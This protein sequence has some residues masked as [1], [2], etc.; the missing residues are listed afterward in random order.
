MD[1]MNITTFAQSG[2]CDKMMDLLYIS[3]LSKLLNIPVYLKKDFFSYTDPKKFKICSWRQI[4]TQYNVL[5]NFINIPQIN[6]V[7]NY[8]S[9]LLNFNNYL[10][11]C[12]N[13]NDFNK[14]Y[15]TTLVNFGHQ[16]NISQELF[17]STFLE[18]CN[19]ITFKNLDINMFPENTI[20]I[21]LRRTD[22]ISNNPDEGMIHTSELDDLDNKTYK[23]IDRLS[24]KY[25][26]FFICSDDL[27]YLQKFKIYIEK[28][29][30]NCFYNK[31]DDFITYKDLYCLSKCTKILMS[32]KSSNFSLFA[33]LIGNKNII[34]IYD[35]DYL[36][37][38]K[39][40]IKFEKYTD[41]CT[42][43]GHQ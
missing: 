16:N 34:N 26:N 43:I 8:D 29:N 21:H 10:G 27:E 5:N 22:K 32:C 19:N 12:S 4:D 7:D 40:I 15:C 9:K 42:I 24:L 20:G 38:Y 23:L 6:F 11:G 39:D 28:L 30:L 14:K 41:S 36:K 18:V 2:L 35:T 31:V 25:K 13:L 3:T 33:S 17:N 37:S 1:I